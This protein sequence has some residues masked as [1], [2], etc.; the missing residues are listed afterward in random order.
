[1]VTASTDVEDGL[2]V[3]V[4]PSA[5]RR[6]LLAALESFSSE[7][8]HATTTRSIATKAGMSPAAMYVHYRSKQAVLMQ[9]SLLGHQASLR[10]IRAAAASESEPVERLRAVVREHT[11]WHARNRD[12]ARVAQ[13]ELI[14]L[15]PENLAEVTTLRKAVRSVLR[16]AIDDGIAAGRFV[17][18]DVDA[19]LQA[20]ASLSIDVARWFPG[21]WR[22]SVDDLADAYADVA[23][24]VV[25]ATTHR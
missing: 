12:V 18:P 24:R 22:G 15:S 14:S 7:G 17:V 2:F 23:T 8:Y 9:I 25:G 10:V 21:G 3:D 13:Y 16:E 4:H 6:L 19:A 20:I 1:M 11:R 5:A